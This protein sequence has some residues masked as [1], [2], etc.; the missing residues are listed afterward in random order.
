[1]VTSLRLDSGIISRV[2]RCGFDVVWLL[3]SVLNF[4]CF[5]EVLCFDVLAF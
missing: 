3:C 4:A 1:M 2:V 5:A